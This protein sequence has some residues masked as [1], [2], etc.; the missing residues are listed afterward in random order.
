M[1]IYA[2]AN[3]IFVAQSCSLWR[4]FL[5]QPAFPVID[6][7]VSLPLTNFKLFEQI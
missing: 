1:L 2:E 5:S 7:G 4:G 6:P 3:N